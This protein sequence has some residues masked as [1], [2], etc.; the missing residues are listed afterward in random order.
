MS[1]SRDFSAW[2]VGMIVATS[3]CFF[4]MVFC[5]VVVWICRYVRERKA[6]RTQYTSAVSHEGQPGYGV[7]NASFSEM[8]DDDATLYWEGFGD[9]AEHGNMPPGPGPDFDEASETDEPDDIVAAPV[10]APLDDSS[11]V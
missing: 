9:D 8:R 6:A 10:Y 11:T 5:V 2:Q 1:N 4:A 7:V 3:L